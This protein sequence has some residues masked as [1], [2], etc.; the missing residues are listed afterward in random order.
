MK[1]VEK[2]IRSSLAK[3][4]PFIQF[5]RPYILLAWLAAAC[6]ADVRFEEPQPAG[7]SDENEIPDRLRGKYTSEEDSS[8]LIITSRVIVRTND[9][10]QVY[11]V[12][13]LDSLTE[14]LPTNDTV[15]IDGQV[16]YEVKRLKEGKYSV[17]SQFSDTL[18]NLSSRQVLRKYKGYYFLSREEGDGSWMVKRITHNR[19]GLVIGSIRS[20]EEMLNL[21][22]I[23]AGVDDSTF[24][25][26]PSRKEFR[27]FLKKNSFMNEEKF[28]KVK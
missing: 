21:R 11:S 16:R 20:K 6:V 3:K 25:F 7:V 4:D 26:K 13:E 27:K 12:K 28:L 9:H 14:K 19:K 22:Q 5:L 17:H 2:F 18:L 1:Q 24:V 10:Q 23:T 15:F 8:L